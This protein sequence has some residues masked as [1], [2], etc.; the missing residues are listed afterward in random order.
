MYVWKETCH[1]K[2]TR[3]SYRRNSRA[4]KS[5]GELHLLTSCRPTGAAR[6]FL[7]QHTKTG[8]NVPS[9]KQKVPNGYSIYHINTKYTKW[10]QNIRTFWVLRPSK[11]YPNWDFWYTNTTYLATL[12]P[13]RQQ[14]MMLFNWQLNGT[15]NRK[16]WM[17]AALEKKWLQSADVHHSV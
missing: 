6:F 11:I 17:T 13:T 3:V 2:R 1:F 9:D 8:K 10:P 5:G 14:E 12:R 4:G 16:L 15:D 7:V